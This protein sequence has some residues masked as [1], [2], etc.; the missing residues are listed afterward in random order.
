M[1][2]D[3]IRQT[4]W[5]ALK[6]NARENPDAPALLTAEKVL[7]RGE[8]RD[9]SLSLAGGLARAGLRKGGRAALAARDYGE[10]FT[11][12]FA[13]WAAGGIAAPMNVTLPAA[14][15]EAILN[16]LDPDL[17]IRGSGLDE[18]DSGSFSESFVPKDSLCSEMIEPAPN[19]PEDE[20]MIMFTSGTT[21]VPK[22]V[23][24]NHGA[25]ALNAGLMAGALN[26]SARD[27]IFIN[28]P[29]Y[30]TSA[31]IHLAHHVFPRGGAGRKER[32]HV[33][34]GHP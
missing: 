29:P 10:F 17:C 15:R 23:Q 33:R 12:L 7:S 2:R 19:R 13:V 3:A 9:K 16:Q 8:F 20:A 34:R 26:L 14:N 31:I 5:D 30:Y 25:L 27:R 28:T 32:V 21:G 11:L 4:P 24:N 1:N 18:L 22:G 6:A